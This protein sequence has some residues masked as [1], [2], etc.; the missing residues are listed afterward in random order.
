MYSGISNFYFNPSTNRFFATNVSTSALIAVSSAAIGTSSLGGNENTLV[1]GLPPAVSPGEGGQILLQASGG[2]YTSAS[3][4]DTYQNQFRVLRGTNTG[5]DAQHF[6]I[7]LHNGQATFN[8]YSGSGAFTGTPVAGLGVDANGNMV[9]S[10]RTGRYG[11]AV[12]GSTIGTGVT[13]QT[14]VYAQ[15]IPANTLVAG[16]IVRTYFRFRKLSTNANATYNILV[17]TSPSVGGATTLATLTANTVHNQ[18]KRDFY[19]AQGNATTTVG[20]GVNVA[21][22]DTTNTQTLSVINWASDQYLIYTVTLGT[23]DSGYGLGYV[24]EQVL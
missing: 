14:I 2:I 8:K 9:S 18:M 21:T 15:L 23:T 13:A 24:I 3:M 12:S 19:I 1:V 17:N 7:N 22:D 4:I 10:T 11:S 6:G 16:D 5:S 20:S